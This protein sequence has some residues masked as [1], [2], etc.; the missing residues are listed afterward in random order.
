M[1]RDKKNIAIIVLSIALVASSIGNIILT[2]EFEIGIAPPLLKT[3]KMGTIRNPLVIDPVVCYEGIGL[4]DR[5]SNDVILQVC[6]GLYMHNLSDPNLRIVPILAADYGIWDATGTKFTIPLR[7]NIFF[8][9]G[10]PFNAA[11]VKW[12]FERI[13]FFINASGTLSSAT[14]I[15]PIRPFYEFP[16]RTTIFDPVSPVTINSDYSVTIHL[17]DQYAILDSLLCN[18]PS[19][20][21]SPNSTPKYEYINITNGKIIGTGPFVYDHFLPDKEVKLHRWARY[22]RTGSYFDQLVFYIADGSTALYEAVTSRSVDCIYGTFSC[23]MCH[24]DIDSYFTFPREKGI[25]FYYL[26]MNNNKINKTW[27]QAISYAISYTY[28]IDELQQGTVYRSNGPLAPPFP[29]YDPSIKVATWNLAKARQILVDAGITNLTVNNDTTGPI[30]DAWKATELKS[31]NYSYNIGNAFRE[32]LGVLLRYNLDLIGIE[33]VD[34]GMSY[35]DYISRAYGD[36]EPGGYDS[37]ELF[38]VGW[39]PD[40]FSPY[41]MIAPLF[42]NQSASNSAQYHNHTVEM[43]LD[44]ILSETNATKR[45]ELYSKILHQIVEIDMPYAF[46]YHPYVP[47]THSKDLKGVPY[48]AMGRFY[49]YPMYRDSNS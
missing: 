2:P 8:H 14:E 16:N 15:S 28:I 47:F 18:T 22:W 9:D 38:W 11:A 19:F 30:A 25:S 23:V 13:N 48:N 31:W 1:E 6:E 27:R 45:A 49:F 24:T 46:G 33:V 12:N 39:S 5:T 3:V 26:G 36:M 35:D 7:R 37:L 32:D 21:L 4:Y 41:N 42:S 17:R 44:E 43:W 34:Q 10:T 29:M 40:Y 20:M